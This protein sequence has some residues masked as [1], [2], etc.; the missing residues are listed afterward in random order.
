ML[1]VML[2]TLDSWQ[3]TGFAFLASQLIATATIWCEGAQNAI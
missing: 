3:N 1:Y 2:L